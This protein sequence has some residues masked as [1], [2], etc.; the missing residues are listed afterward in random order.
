M[1]GKEKE[2][3]TIA[4]AKEV[5]QDLL[6]DFN[7]FKSEIVERFQALEVVPSNPPPTIDMAQV[8]E[9]VVEL[10]NSVVSE[11]ETKLDSKI[12][13]RLRDQLAESV[14]DTLA[15]QEPSLSWEKGLEM[16]MAGDPKVST[17]A[18]EAFNAHLNKTGKELGV[19]H[20]RTISVAEE[21]EVVQANET[22]SDTFTA[23]CPEL[24]QEVKVALS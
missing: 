10:A 4:E 6:S 21:N 15:S 1:P 20:L 8:E 16:L 14:N 12:D 13:D 22:P 18:I 24:G 5:I 7:T 11:L 17:Q 9:R 2:M 19:K 23:W 3:R